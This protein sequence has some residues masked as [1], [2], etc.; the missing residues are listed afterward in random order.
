[1]RDITFY[2]VPDLAPD[3][4]TGKPVEILRPKIPI[5]LVLNHKMFPHIIEALFDTGSDRNLF[6]ADFAF[7]L[8]TKVE[9]GKPIKIGGIGISNEII[10]YTHRVSM[11]VGDYKIGTE[12]DF[13]KEHNVPILGR[14]GFID[15]FENIEVNEK[16]KFVKLYYK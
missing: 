9:K 5:R 14:I 15:K 12:I 16:K 10:A 13:S 3:R 1:M 2:Y 7:H 4:L 11:F 8:G 6:P